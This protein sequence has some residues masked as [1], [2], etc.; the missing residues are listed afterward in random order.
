MVGTTSPLD[1]GVVARWHLKEP[2][3]EPVLFKEGIV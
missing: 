1:P 3:R 2:G